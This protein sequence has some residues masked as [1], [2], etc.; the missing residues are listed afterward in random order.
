MRI[1]DTEQIEGGDE[2]GTN[3]GEQTR[4]TVLRG[5]VAT[6]GIGVTTGVGSHLL[7]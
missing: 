7:Y 1:L 5:T 4:R 6:L 2:G 3:L